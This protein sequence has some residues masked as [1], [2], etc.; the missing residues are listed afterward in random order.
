MNGDMGAR[1]ATYWHAL[2]GATG[3]SAGKQRLEDLIEELDQ[4]GY[5]AA[6]KCL[7]DDLD[8]ADPE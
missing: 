2:D 5:T 6:A 3:D 7:A 4:G 1:R 8:A